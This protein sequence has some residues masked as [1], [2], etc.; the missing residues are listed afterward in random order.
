MIIN[1]IN[2]VVNNALDK[3]NTDNHKAR[4]TKAQWRLQNI[5]KQCFQLEFIQLSKSVH[6]NTIWHT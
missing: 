6:N 5:F 1:I 3:N 4:I 2:Y